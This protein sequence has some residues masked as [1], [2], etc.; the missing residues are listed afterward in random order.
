MLLGPKMRYLG[1]DINILSLEAM[2]N[3]FEIAAT[4]LKM[5][6]ERGDP[7]SGPIPSKLQPG[8]TVLVQNHTKG[9]FNP[10]YVGD[11]CVV[12]LKGNQ[13]EVQPSTGGPTEMKHIKHVKYIF[14]ADRYIKQ[15]PDYSASGRKAALRMNPDKIPDLQWQLASTYHTTNIGQLESQTS[16]ISTSGVDVDTISH[17][18]GNKYES[19]CETT[20]NTDTITLQ[21][22]NYPIACFDLPTSNRI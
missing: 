3:M 6:R 7:Q 4:N 16:D 5:A 10:K 8:D 19:L 15:I 22:N 12:S 14:P 13:V 21:S 1:N 18:G 17:A 2:K 11:Y 20:L 9:P